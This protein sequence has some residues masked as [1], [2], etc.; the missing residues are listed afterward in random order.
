MPAGSDAPVPDRHT[1]VEVTTDLD[2]YREAG[3]PARTM[4]RDLDAD[5]D[6][7]AAAL[8]AGST[9]AGMIAT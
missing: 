4:G 2:G 1:R 5:P 6:F 9:L 8:A 7:F 3:L